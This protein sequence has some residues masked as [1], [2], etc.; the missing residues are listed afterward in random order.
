MGRKTAKMD[1][2]RIRPQWPPTVPAP[3]IRQFQPNPLFLLLSPKSIVYL[4]ESLAA[5]FVPLF[6]CRV[7]SP[8]FSAGEAAGVGGSGMASTISSAAVFAM[9]A[10]S[11]NTAS[12]NP[13]GPFRPRNPFRYNPLSL[14][15][16]LHRYF[17][18]LRVHH[19][20]KPV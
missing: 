17:L 10:S 7:C 16:L 4:G 9:T 1:L 8:P 20:L 12:R 11:R 5:G 18:P 19:F 6:C 2:P 3:T 15:G 14:H 13:F